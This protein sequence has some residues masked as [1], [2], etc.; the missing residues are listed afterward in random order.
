MSYVMLNKLVLRLFCS[1]LQN[2]RRFDCGS[3]STCIL[4]TRVND[5]VEGSVM[6]KFCS[7]PSTGCFVFVWKKKT[8]C[9]LS[10]CRL[11]CSPTVYHLSKSFPK[12]HT[13]CKDLTKNLTPKMFLNPIMNCFHIFWNKKIKNHAWWSFEIWALPWSIKILWRHLRY[14]CW[15]V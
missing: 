10:V 11:P 15:G 2:L 9:I 6:C 13:V 4:C 8:S 7:I 14:G 12:K 3:E 1:N 5:V